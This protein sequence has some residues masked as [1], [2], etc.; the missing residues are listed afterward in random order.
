MTSS[1]SDVILL[2]FCD[3]VYNKQHDNKNRWVSTPGDVILLLLCVSF[4]NKQST[5]LPWCRSTV[6]FLIQQMLQAVLHS[7]VLAKLV[8]SRMKQPAVSCSCSM[9]SSSWF[10]KSNSESKFS[11]AYIVV[12]KQYITKNM[13]VSASGDVILLLIGNLVSNKQHVTKNRWVNMLRYDILLIVQPSL[14]APL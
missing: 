6:T 7:I 5:L 13:W 12:M 10:E 11:L 9:L 14:G 1:S 4:H 8:I 3:L 2:L